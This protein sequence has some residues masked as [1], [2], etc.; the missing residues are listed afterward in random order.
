MSEGVGV[1]IG[2]RRS[3]VEAERLVLE[4]EQSGLTQQAFCALHGLSVGT[5]DHYRKH[6]TPLDHRGA[7]AATP[8]ILPVELV[9]GVGSPSCSRMENRGALWVVLANG[10]RIKVAHGFDAVTLERLVVVLEQA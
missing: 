2:R 7:Q 6:R 4:F 3:R 9:N 1:A 10:R 5:L 8:R